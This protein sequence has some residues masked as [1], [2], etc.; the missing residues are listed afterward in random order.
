MSDSMRI[1]CNNVPRLLLNWDQLTPQE[2]KDFDYLSEDDRI[3]RDFV[4]YRGSAYDLGEFMRIDKTVAPHCQRPNWEKFD[5][6]YS[7][8][9][10]SAVLVRY[11]EDMDHVIM[12][13]ALS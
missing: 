13:L 2:R 4:R 9:F 5:G 11:T 10:F 6:Y 12:A 8:T 7:E 3:G 1:I